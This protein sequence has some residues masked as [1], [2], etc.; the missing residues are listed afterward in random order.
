MDDISE[1]WKIQRSSF[2]VSALVPETRL[3]SL[4]SMSISRVSRFFGATENQPLAAEYF[5]PFFFFLF[6]FVPADKRCLS[7]NVFERLMHCS[8]SCGKCCNVSHWTCFVN[9]WRSFLHSRAFSVSRWVYAP[10]IR[11]K[12]SASLLGS[13]CALRDISCPGIYVSIGPGITLHRVKLHR[14]IGRDLQAIDER[15]RSVIESSF[16]INPP[17]PYIP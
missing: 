5:Y 17:P 10:C 13:I 7:R 4:I 8:E 14:C 6:Y 1:Y 11:K 16:K 9:Q 2:D 15:S 12:R 3:F